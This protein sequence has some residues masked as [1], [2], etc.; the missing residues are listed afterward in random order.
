MVSRW[1]RIGGAPGWYSLSKRKSQLE[2]KAHAIFLFTS[3][4]LVT[5]NLKKLVLNKWSPDEWMMYMRNF[6]KFHIAVT[7]KSESS[8][9]NQRKARKGITDHDPKH[10]KDKWDKGRNIFEGRKPER[11]GIRFII[12]VEPT[13]LQV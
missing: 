1:G 2:C 9:H 12:Y 3:V 13:D 10:A 8:G 5:Q 6:R 7:P 4:L 11:V